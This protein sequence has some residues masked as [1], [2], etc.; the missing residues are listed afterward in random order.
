MCEPC[1]LGDG[2]ASTV[3]VRSDSLSATTFL[4]LFLFFLSSIRGSFRREGEEKGLLLSLS[5][6]GYSVIHTRD[7]NVNLKR[8]LESK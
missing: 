5:L 6:R 7:K 2:V 3:C 1:V 4:S 8:G